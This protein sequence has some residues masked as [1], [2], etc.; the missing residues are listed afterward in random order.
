MY[1]RTQLVELQRGL[2]EFEAA[3]V[4]VVAISYDPPGALAQFCDEHGITF[5]FLSDDGSRLIQQLGILNTL[6]EPDEPVYGIPY[7]GAYLLDEDGV[8][9]AK[10]FHREYQVREAPSFVLA[11]GFGLQP[12]LEGYPSARESIDGAAVEVV[13][14]APDLK[15]WQRVNLHTRVTPL[16]GWTLTEAPVVRVTTAADVHIEAPRAGL[17]D[18]ETRIELLSAVRAAEAD[19]AVAF[20]IELTCALRGPDGARAERTIELRLEVP[21]GAMNRA[22]PAG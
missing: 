21:V 18:G 19:E 4:W 16:G 6:I 5:P 20:D 8:I 3:G 1:C 14:G 17:V 11:E 22:R 13:L 7:P 2:P 10:F 15:F 9:V 12:N